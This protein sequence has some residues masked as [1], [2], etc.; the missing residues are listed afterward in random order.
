MIKKL[1]NSVNPT[2]FNVK[3]GTSKSGNIDVPENGQEKIKVTSDKHVQ[4][5]D[6]LAQLHQQRKLEEKRLKEEEQA[7]LERRELERQRHRTR[8]QQQRRLLE[9]QK[10]QRR[11]RNDNDIYLQ[12]DQFLLGDDFYISSAAYRDANTADTPSRFIIRMAHAIWPTAELA[13]RVIRK[14]SNTG[15]RKSLTPRKVEL[16][17]YRFEEFLVD[18]NYSEERTG[19]E[20]AK[21]N[22][23]LGESITSAKK[24]LGFSKGKQSN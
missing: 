10:Q 7:I 19:F 23:Y 17:S 18:R 9:T 2:K 4:L 15:D 20:L 22:K 1:P 3:P 12:N 16:L 13:Q 24:K 14:Q 8:V 21:M 6:H 11:N 5:D